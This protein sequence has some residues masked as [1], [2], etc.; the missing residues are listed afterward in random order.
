MQ[1]HLLE[2]V[3][4]GSITRETAIEKTGNPDLFKEIDEGIGGR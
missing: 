3:E 2:L 1:M 4:N